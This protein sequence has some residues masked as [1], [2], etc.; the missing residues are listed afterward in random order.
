M[1]LQCKRDNYMSETRL[2][3]CQWDGRK[4]KKQLDRYEKTKRK[5]SVIDMPYYI[6][7]IKHVQDLWSMLLDICWCIFCVLKV[8]SLLIM[9]EFIFWIS[10]YCKLL[11][12]FR[13]KLFCFQSVTKTWLQ[14]SCELYC[15][16]KYNNWL[17]QC[18][19]RKP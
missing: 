15:Y 7:C 12:G 19:E 2:V 4:K 13:N 11:W 5:T 8:L 3:V 6:G 14:I 10:K 9:L 16:D 18:Y 1:H 17:L